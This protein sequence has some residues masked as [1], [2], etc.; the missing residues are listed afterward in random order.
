MYS[1]HQTFGPCFTLLIYTI[2]LRIL[3]Y[4]IIWY[5]TCTVQRLFKADIFVDIFTACW[6]IPCKIYSVSFLE[7]DKVITAEMSC[8]TGAVYVQWGGTDPTGP[9]RGHLESYEACCS[10]P[11]YIL[12]QSQCV[13]FSS[14]L[15]SPS[16]T[17][18]SQL[19]FITWLNQCRG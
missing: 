12:R 14:S 9:F 2:L 16:V 1:L 10:C 7:T 8:T 18:Y 15:P 4:A 11:S 6:D 13:T 19:S 3:C 5:A 17:D